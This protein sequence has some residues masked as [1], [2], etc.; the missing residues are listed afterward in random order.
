MCRSCA[1]CGVC[2]MVEAEARC[3]SVAAEAVRWCVCTMVEA[4]AQKK[5]RPQLQSVSGGAVYSAR[6]VGGIYSTIYCT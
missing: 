3:G 2:T 1:R 5:N 6:C 4:E